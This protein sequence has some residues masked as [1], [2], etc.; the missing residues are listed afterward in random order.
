LGR[1]V[2]YKASGEIGVIGF[3]EHVL[4]SQ[5]QAVARV[6]AVPEADAGAYGTAE[7]ALKEYDI[8]VAIGITLGVG[9]GGFLTRGCTQSNSAEAQLEYTW[10]RGSEQ[11]RKTF[12][13]VLYI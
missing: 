3:P 2:A 5:R 6:G 13:D 7:R 4:S 10:V 8:G 12:D 9:H 11:A 1:K